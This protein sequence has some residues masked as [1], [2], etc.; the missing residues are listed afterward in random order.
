M[1]KHVSTAAAL[2]EECEAALAA[3]GG[4]LQQLGNKLSPPRHPDK[5]APPI[6]LPKPVRRPPPPGRD[7]DTSRT[8]G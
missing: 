6:G 2:A 8:A 7:V 3:L 4:Q 1:K 5:T